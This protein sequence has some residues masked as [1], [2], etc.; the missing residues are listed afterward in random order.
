MTALVKRLALVMEPTAT[1]V[2]YFLVSTT[3]G[4]NMDALRMHLQEL[5][6]S[7][8]E[9]GQTLPS[10][11]AIMEQLLEEVKETIET[12]VISRKEVAYTSHTVI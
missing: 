7:Q 8:P 6:L 11:Y 3:T 10:S 5:I 2:Q 9:M 1:P 12:P 4:D